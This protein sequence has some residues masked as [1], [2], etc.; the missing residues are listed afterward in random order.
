[1]NS[2]HQYID[3]L[4][5]CFFITQS[6]PYDTPFLSSDLIAGFA[7]TDDAHQQ[8]QKGTG[9]TSGH[10]KYTKGTAIAALSTIQIQMSGPTL[11]SAMPPAKTVTKDMDHSP[12]AP[13]APPRWRCLI[14]A[15]CARLVSRSH[16]PGPVLLSRHR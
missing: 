6:L 4:C 5:L 13:A 15:I 8:K 7:S 3:I 16:V 11:V 9:R 2:Q 10:I 1:M 12:K 14:G